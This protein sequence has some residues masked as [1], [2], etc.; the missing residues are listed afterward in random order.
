MTIIIWYKDDEDDDGDG[1]SFLLFS[2]RLTYYCY[3]YLPTGRLTGTGIVYLPY[4]ICIYDLLVQRI[5]NDNNSQTRLICT[6]NLPFFVV[7]FETQYY[8]YSLIFAVDCVQMRGLSVEKYNNKYFRWWWYE[9]H[10]T[11]KHYY[12]IL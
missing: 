2:S 10:L 3:Y 11:T 8:Y 5:N 6:F 12:S 9:F 7:V 4:I 1:L